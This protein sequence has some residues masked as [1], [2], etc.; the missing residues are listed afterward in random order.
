MLAAIL[1][2]GTSTMLTSCGDNEDNPVEPSKQIVGKWYA[3]NNTPGSINA[4]GISID[5]QKLV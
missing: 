2:C 1:I 3:E 5:Y 4:D